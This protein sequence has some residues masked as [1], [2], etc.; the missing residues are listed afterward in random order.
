MQTMKR[1]LM[2][3]LAAFAL[4]ACGDDTGTNPDPDPSTHG[5]V[6]AAITDGSGASAA[7]F[8]R[9]GAGSAN[10]TIQAD[11]QVEIQTQAGAWVDVGNPAQVNVA[12]Q[13]NGSATVISGDVLVPVGTYSRVRL[14]MENAEAH[15]LAG[16][17]LGVLTLTADVDIVIGGSDGRVIVEYTVS[18]F[19]VQAGGTVSTELL[20]DLNSEAWLTQATAEAQVVADGAVQSGSTCEPR[21]KDSQA[22]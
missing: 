17:V 6:R 9:A 15:L 2:A 7:M 4:V 10:G 21:P 3:P 18:P 13:S 11:V 12:A 14:T 22:N 16:S 1:I 8:S 20:F 19:T 5:Y